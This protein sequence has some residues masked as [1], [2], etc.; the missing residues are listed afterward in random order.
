M[1]NTVIA[2]LDVMST[3]RCPTRSAIAPVSGAENADEYV[4]KPRKSPEAKVDPPRSRM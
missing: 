3:F 1:E 4:R 2:T